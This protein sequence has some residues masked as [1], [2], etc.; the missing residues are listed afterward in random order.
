MYPLDAFVV[1]HGLI[2][3]GETMNGLVGR[4]TDVGPPG[5][6]TRYQLRLARGD[7]VMI[8][9]SSLG[10]QR[11]KTVATSSPCRDFILGF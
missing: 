10:I 3:A 6:S 11:E 8:P 5:P 7:T 4:V 9:N 1:I 2:Y